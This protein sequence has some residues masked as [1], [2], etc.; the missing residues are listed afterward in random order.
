MAQAIDVPFGARDRSYAVNF[1]NAETTTDVRKT[2]F[3]LVRPPNRIE[4]NQPTPLVVRSVVTTDGPAGPVA[5]DQELA[6]V[7]KPEDCTITGTPAARR[8]VLGVGHSRTFDDVLTVTCA[9]RSDRMFSFRN[10]VT[11]ATPDVTATVDVS[12]PVLEQTQLALGGLSLICD[13]YWSGNPFTCTATA[14]ATNAGAAPD[15]K[16]VATLTLA[17]SAACATAPARP[18]PHGVLVGAGAS[19]V[20]T[21]T[22]SDPARTTGCGRSAS[23]PTYG[24]TSHTLR[25]RPSWPRS[26]GRRS[27]SSRTAIRTR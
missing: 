17:G 14:T 2:A 13:Q 15:A 20:V 5:E 3:S 1:G 26:S 22:W 24:W 23:Q 27:T 4:I 6:I 21:S 7:S 18:Q 19:Q 9:K 12:V 25:P 11:V 16:L 8:A 10:D